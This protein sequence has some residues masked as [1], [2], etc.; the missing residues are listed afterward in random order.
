M[1]NR[2]SRCVHV[3][4]KSDAIIDRKAQLILEKLRKYVEFTPVSAYIL[5]IT[6]ESLFDWNPT[7]ATLSSP[8]RH[9][10]VEYYTR[11]MILVKSIHPPPTEAG[12][13]KLG[14]AK[15]R[16]R[17]EL[18]ADG[19]SNLLHAPNNPVEAV[20]EYAA[21]QTNLYRIGEN[22]AIIDSGGMMKKV[23]VVGDSFV[24]GVGDLDRGGWAVR[25]GEIA[26]ITTIVNGVGGR[27]SIDVLDIVDSLP[28][29][30]DLAILQ[31]G[32]NDSRYRDS[33][34]GQEVELNIF[35]K[36]VSKIVESL[37]VKAARVAIMGLTRVNEDLTDPYKPDK[38]YRNRLI[39]DYDRCL[40]DMALG[41]TF[42]YIPVSTLGERPGL[43]SD[44]LHPSPLGHELLLG[45]VLSYIDAKNVLSGNG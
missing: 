43:L 24:E 8:E 3:I 28:S 40:R 27:T 9:K 16:I 5:L 1:T 37:N 19:M 25:L 2:D 44:G 32:L 7:L 11:P 10:V 41:G 13:R 38:S 23:L 30:F 45:S 15:Q 36:A 42:D 26:D 12:Y 34:T 14:L 6:Q 39:D 29:G 21:Y 20:Q 18:G 22:S 4:L 31:V 33:L 17:E 35:K